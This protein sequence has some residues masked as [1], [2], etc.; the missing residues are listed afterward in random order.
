M[1]KELNV[2]RAKLSVCVSFN[3]FSPTDSHRRLKPGREYPKRMLLGSCVIVGRV[4]LPTRFFPSN[5]F[6][7]QFRPLTVEKKPEE[8]ANSLLEK[9]ILETFVGEGKEEEQGKFLFYIL[10]YPKKQETERVKPLSRRV[11][12]RVFR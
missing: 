2:A 9:I 5:S 6:F 8:K 3:P 10:F 1:G 11:V 7:S 12:R 4:L